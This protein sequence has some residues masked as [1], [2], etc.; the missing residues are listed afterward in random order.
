MTNLEK[1]SKDYK[2]Q[3]D[4]NEKLKE[5]LN[6]LIKQNQ[7]LMTGIT[8]SSEQ[9]DTSLPKNTI[10][11]NIA[12]ENQIIENSAIKYDNEIFNLKNLINDKCKN[13][14]LN[15]KQVEDKLNNKPNHSNIVY[16]EVNN[17]PNCKK[18]DN[19][20]TKQDAKFQKPMKSLESFQD[21]DIIDYTSKFTKN[22]QITNEFN[23]IPIISMQKLDYKSLILKVYTT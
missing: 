19:N 4:E 16:N 21:E 6:L 5:R 15:I 20:V 2:I 17:S 9:K 10:V 7:Q 18:P 3:I 22:N 1:T 14:E 23:K 12:N 13:F 8:K 11:N